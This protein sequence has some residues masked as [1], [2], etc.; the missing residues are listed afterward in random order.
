MQLIVEFN[1]ILVSSYWVMLDSMVPFELIFFF[2]FVLRLIVII[3]LNLSVA[4]FQENHEVQL[5]LTNDDILGDK[6][7][8]DQEAVFRQFCYQSLKLPGVVVS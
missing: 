4:M 5:V 3:V 7:P 2:L 6:I 1:T 8:Y